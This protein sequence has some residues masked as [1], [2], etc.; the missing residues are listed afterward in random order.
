MR[1]EEGRTKDMARVARETLEGKYFHI[2]VSGIDELKI[3]NEHKM[4][5]YYTELLLKTKGISFS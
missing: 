4:K 1:E 5:A 2:L 3:F